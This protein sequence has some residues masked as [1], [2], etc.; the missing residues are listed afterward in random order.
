MQS[1]LYA[2]VFVADQSTEHPLGPA[3]STIQV[4][5]PIYDQ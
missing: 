3:A 4:E 5:P 2:G 1:Y